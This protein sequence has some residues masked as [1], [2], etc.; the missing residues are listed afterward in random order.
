M[1]APSEFSKLIDQ[2]AGHLHAHKHGA[3][4]QDIADFLKI[5]GKFTSSASEI[6][7]PVLS[8]FLGTLLKK[9]KMVETAKLLWSPNQFTPDPQSVKD[10]WKL[11]EETSQG[12]VM[13]ASSLGK[14]FSLGVRF[15]LEWARDPQW[16]SIRV[17]GPSENHLEQNLF[18]H[19]V[20]LHRQATIPIPG[21]VGDLFIGLDRRDQLG[22][23]RGV[24]I[25]KSNAKKSGRLQGGHRRPRP[26]PHPIFGPLSRMYIFIDEIENVP[27]G[28]WMDVDN[29]L[30]EIKTDHETGF[31]IFGAF[32]PSDRSA[33]V[34]EKVEPEFGWEIFDE[35]KHFR[36][37]SLKGWDVLRLDGER[38][39][40]VVQGKV[41]YPGLQTREGL[42]RIAKNAGGRQSAGYCTMGRGIYPKQGAVLTVIPPGMW[43]KLKGT[44]IWLSDPLPVAATDSALDGG[45]A[46]I[47]M[48]GLWGLATGW[49]TRPTEEF[50][51]GKVIIFKDEQGKNMPRYGLQAVN[52]FSLEPGDTIKMK[53]QILRLN[54]KAGIRPE[55]FAGDATGHTRGTMDLLKDEWSNAI[56]SVNYSSGATT[57]KLMREDTHTCAELYDRMFTELWFGFRVWAE[58]GYVL[59]DP[60][61]DCTKLGPQITNRRFYLTGGGRSRVESK[62][63]Y[64]LRMPES[65]NE[66]DALTLLVY[67]A[68][69]GSG[70]TLSMRG[71]SILPRDLDMD[72]WPGD[73]YHGGA[74]IDPSNTSDFLDLREHRTEMESPIL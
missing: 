40:N 68:R 36:W 54:R 49:K 20:N 27:E 74:R 22:S 24:V 18:S 14:S 72:D 30:G 48:K 69:K 53:D 33:K 46:A 58:F 12:L 1:V 55:F 35:D 25:P 38:C 71:E 37:K 10:L 4:A 70:V 63:D 23:I 66:A 44:F 31:G 2:A 3:A 11:F 15:Y 17:I 43:E 13:G 41:V 29:V 52:F 9:G 50:P 32:N 47:W 62:Q 60:A 59:I 64:K 56:Q 45:D 21:E 42:E 67:A 7:M 19:L 8:S 39:E 34:A 51:N 73:T 65:P 61:M 16:T 57:D 28:I 6:H 26:V 5:P